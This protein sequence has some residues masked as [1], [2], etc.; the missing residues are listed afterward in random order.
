MYEITPSLNN[1]P[2][3][4]VIIRVIFPFLFLLFKAMACIA[5]FTY[6]FLTYPFP[7]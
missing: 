1:F 3:L 6:R 7:F 2:W 5:N 4:P